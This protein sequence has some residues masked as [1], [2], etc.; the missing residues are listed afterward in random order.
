MASELTVCHIEEAEYAMQQ[1]AK[2]FEVS[3]NAL[4]V[5]VEHGRQS[6]QLGRSFLGENTGRKPLRQQLVSHQRMLNEATGNGG[7]FLRAVAQNLAKAGAYGWRESH[8]IR[9]L[10]K[11]IQE[12]SDDRFILL[13]S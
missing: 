10:A 2:V 1:R 4:A 8:G 7:D 13:P 11:P 9:K 3:L 6:A 5:H 12:W